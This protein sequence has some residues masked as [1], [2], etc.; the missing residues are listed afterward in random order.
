MKRLLLLLVVL[1]FFINAQTSKWINNNIS[2]RAFVKN[3]G[4]YDGK[5]WQPK[6]AI[7][8]ALSQ[9][10]GWFTFFTKKGITHRLERLIRNPNKTKDNPNAPSRVQ[11]SEF[12]NVFFVGTNPNVKIIAKNKT[13]HYFS[14]A[15]RDKNTNDVKNIYNV[16]GYKIITYK[17]I[18]D[19]IDI[20]YTLHPKGGIKY[21]VILHPGANPSQIK[22]KYTSNHTNYSNE[23]V[24][25]NLNQSGQ[26]EIKTSKTDLIE[27]EPHTFYETNKSAIKSKYVFNNDVL[28]FDIDNYDN[29]KE[30]IIDPW[31]ITPNFNASAGGAFV[32]EVETDGAGNIYAIGGETPMELRKY[33]S[34]GSL[35][36]TYSSPWSASSNPN[37]WLGTLATDNAGVSYITQGV[38]AEI[39]RISTAGAMVWHDNGPGGFLDSY[40]YWSITFNCDNTKLIVGGTHVN[41][42]LFEAKIY[43]INLSNGTVISDVTVGTQSGT[44]PIEVRSIA[45]TKN[46]KYVYLTHTEVGVIDQNLT[47]CAGA[48]PDFEVDNQHH[49]GYKCETFLS[50]SQNGGGLK[51]LVANDNYFYTHT[52]TQVLQWDVNTGALLNTVSLPGGSSTVSLGVLVVDCSGLDVDAAGNVYAGSMDR[53]VKFD[54]NLNILSTA[55]TTGG[56]TVYDVSVNSNGEVLACGALSDNSVTTGRGGRIESLNMSAGGQYSSVCCDPNFCPV[57][58]LCTTDS[59][60]NLNPNTTG[61]TWSSSPTTAGLNTSTGVFDPSIAGAGTYTITYTL[62]CGN[63]SITITVGSC[64]AMTACLESNGDITVSGGTSPF[65]WSEWQ[66]G[67]TTPITNSTECT[68][69]GGTWNAFVGQCFNPFPT[70]LDSCTSPAGWVSFTTGTTVTPPAGVD[71]IQIVDSFGNTL[72]TT[73]STLSPCST[74]CDATITQAGPFCANAASTTLTAAQT[75]GTWS[76]NGIIS[77][78]NG[79]FDPAAAGVGNHVI[80]YTLSCGSTDTMTIVINPLDSVGFSYAQGSYC[81]TDP[82]PTPTNTGL[83][84][85]TYTINNSG[86]INAS[87]GQINITASGAGNYTVTYTT[88]GACPNTGTFNVVLTSGANATITQVPP[89]CSNNN[90]F[91]ALTAVDAGGVWSGTGVTG[92]NFDP[93][94]A[95]VGSHVITYTISGSC[96]DVDTMTIVVNASDSAYISYAQ[97]SY[98]L[99]DPN[100]TPTLTGTTGGTYTINNGGTINASTGQINIAVSGAGSY[101]VTY[102][103]SGACP[104]TVTTNVIINNCTLPQPVASFSA[105][106][107]N[108]CTGDCISFT[109]LSTSSASGGITNW[110]WSFTGASTT[111]STQQNPTNICYPTA[112]NYQVMLTVT[113]AN[114]T[115]DTIMTNYIN[116]T[117]CTLPTA[118]FG[119]SDSTICAG[120]C[121]NFTDMSTGATSWLWTFNGGTPSSSTNQNP[122]NICFNTD[123]NYIIKLVVSNS[124]GSDSSTLNLQVNATPTIDAGTDVTIN[125]GESTVLNATGTN[126]TYT[127]TPPDWLSCILC[128]TTTATPDETITYTVSVVDSNGCVATD[129]VSVVVNFENVIF[130]PNIFSPNGDGSNDVLYVR[131]K[132]IASFDFIVYDRWGE[133]VFETNDL[134]T[135]WDGT[136]RGKAMNKAV[137]VYYLQATFIDGNEVKQKGDITL[138]R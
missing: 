94:T 124:F 100:P 63:H 38:G 13:S 51:A 132:G 60:V 37:R 64:S 42:L 10:D 96:G 31:I 102:A 125:L 69:C 44:T 48:G 131:G 127:W 1:P 98:C 6:N 36:W 134:V 24:L 122:T 87:T 53:V 76:G 103:T 82:N 19:N 71:S 28:T 81:L 65:T 99:T 75:G 16:A 77:P 91:I 34:A 35:Q 129:Q 23:N 50:A 20:E 3:E 123:S 128:P 107:T 118:S 43:N 18:Y 15:V 14:Y 32:R 7:E 21:N 30:V 121:I 29:S 101:T 26:L 73:I 78:T 70:P 117:S 106:L 115:D 72:I 130:V 83:S 119:I 2:D 136:F 116:V 67:S 59:P 93:V 92:A 95:G 108:I 137:F 74:T 112:G 58:P 104:D 126:G 85:G 105:S 113:D 55:M 5:N 11:T 9:Q 33:N 110:S 114:G 61:G 47:A 86:T 133:K 4:Q 138:I 57:G 46:S 97:G 39:E 25:F 27:H 80:T 22:M 17:N 84:G 8:Y 52:G 109:D 54:A 111:T 40:E 90:N 89:V 66:Q 41:G 79:T 56:F 12:V 68:A 62:A 88:N 49:L 135:G 45:P 120:N